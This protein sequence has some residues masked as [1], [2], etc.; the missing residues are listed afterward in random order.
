MKERLL[1]A[2]SIVPEKDG[3]FVVTFPDIP[4][5]LT[6][7]ST[8]DEALAS[9]E[10]CLAEAIAGRIDDGEDIPTP[11]EINENEYAIVCPPQLAL[12]AAVYELLQERHIS[13]VKL[14]ELLGVNEKEARRISDPHHNTRL[15]T[16]TSTLRALGKQVT[17]SIQDITKT[18]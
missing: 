14:A 18:A 5:A 1:Y 6:D 16:L 13:K 12:K 4:E 17:V 10:D 15:Q 11:S 9:A 2:A 3:G 7:G 8:L